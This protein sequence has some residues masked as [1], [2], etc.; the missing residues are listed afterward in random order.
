MLLYTPQMLRK[1]KKSLQSWKELLFLQLA[2]KSSKKIH[3]FVKVFE[4]V[5]DNMTNE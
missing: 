4:K 2:Q 1:P 5:A 3:K